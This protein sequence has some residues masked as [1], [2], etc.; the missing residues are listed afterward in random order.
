MIHNYR[1]KRMKK[2]ITKLE[3]LLSFYTLLRSKMVH[4]LDKIDVLYMGEKVSESEYQK[5]TDEQVHGKTRQEWI[6]HYNYQINK[7]QADLQR[8]TDRHSTLL[9]KDRSPL[10]AGIEKYLFAIILVFIIVQTLYLGGQ[11]T[12]LFI[13]QEPQYI[14]NVSLSF[15]KNSLYDHTLAFEPTS[16]RLTG[17]VI[18]DGQVKIYLVANGTQYLVLNDSIL[19]EEGLISIT[20]LVVTNTSE[21]EDEDEDEDEEEEGLTNETITNETI[22]NVTNQTINESLNLT[23]NQTINENLTINVS[24]NATTNVSINETPTNVTVIQDLAPIWLDTLTTITITKN[25]NGTINLSQHFSDPNGDNLTYLSTGPENIGVLIF[26]ELI[27]LEPATNFTGQESI[28]FIASD[29][30]FSTTSPVIPIIVQ[31]PENITVENVTIIPV[32]ITAFTQL[33]IETCILSGVGKDIQFVIEV[34]NAT[35]NITEISYTFAEE[36]VGNRAPQFVTIPNQTL[37]QGSILT[38]DLAEYS[39]DADDDPL[40]YL[41]TQPD[42]FTVTILNELITLEPEAQ[43]IGNQTIQFIVSDLNLSSFSNEVVLEVLVN[44]SFNITNRAPVVSPIPDIIIEK[45]RNKTINLDNYFSDPDNQSLVYSASQPDNITVIVAQNLVSLVPD[46][47]FVGARMINFSASD[48]VDTTT[49]GPVALT[50]VDNVTI[51]NKTERTI[52]VLAE[53]NKPVR[54]VKKI[55]LNQSADNITVNITAAASNITVAKIV[56]GQKIDITGSV[57]IKLNK[58]TKNLSEFMEESNLITG[59]VIIEQGGRGLFSR[60]VDTVTQGGITGRA[61]QNLPQTTNISVDITF[62]NVTEL[63]IVDNATDF[64]IEYQTEAPR[65]IERN[66]SLKVKQVVVSSALPY[67]NILTYTELRHEVPEE[68]LKLFWLV[69]KSEFNK[70]MNISEDIPVISNVTNS[71]TINQTIESSARTH[72]LDITKL[73]A[74]GVR[75]Y[76]DNNNGLIDLIEW[77]TPHLS[78]QTFEIEISILNVQS[79]PQVGANWTV[80]FTTIGT[81]NLTITAVNETSY[82]EMLIDDTS[83]GDDLEILSLICN[84]TSYFDKN[85]NIS[86]GTEF[87]LSNGSVVGYSDISDQSL[88]V[89]SLFIE[90]YSCGGIGFLTVRVITEGV[91]NQMFQFGFD[92]GFANNL[93]GYPPITDIIVFSD[94]NL[95]NII[96]IIS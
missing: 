42:H 69:N 88:D 17:A 63:I 39:Y 7:T 32:K 95:T 14:E 75:T 6:Q 58:T 23:I 68:A 94:R 96:N 16:L 55:S 3:N 36:E 27:T 50:V 48:S 5:E 44:E 40:T 56:G 29:L 15:S 81:A 18:G 70:Y 90:N 80:Q 19:Q 13:L 25:T 12:G 24:V 79:Y 60:F 38:L 74:F 86:S 49:T 53:I 34:D 9:K 37:Y 45:N 47:E 67:L 93:A 4:S 52:Q 77:V 84:T 8:T 72:R 83:S 26:N 43:F 33:C 82:T 71:S 54:W 22:Q 31:E 87:I 2:K 21:D 28:Q 91:H 51:V 11:L 89:S 66:V 35:V 73:P 41:S 64:E 76:D 78:N 20:G 57:L 46:P 61:V 30:S 62:T 59:G 1:L 10:I 65:A 85:K 92:F